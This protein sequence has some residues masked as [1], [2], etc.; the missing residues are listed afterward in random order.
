MYLYYIAF[1]KNQSWT[2]ETINCYLH[3][4]NLNNKCN[5]EIIED[6][7]N[8]FFKVFFLSDD[9][10][11]QKN[12]DNK[13]YTVKYPLDNCIYCFFQLKYAEESNIIKHELL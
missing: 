10:I 12:E 9:T 5:P 2:L 8:N 1:F 4:R 6:K 7:E 11:K 3:A 13:L